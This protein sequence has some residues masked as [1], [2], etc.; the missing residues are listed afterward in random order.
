ME[1]SPPSLFPP[2]AVRFVRMHVDLSWTTRACAG[3]KRQK[4][5]AIRFEQ[6]TLARGL[7]SSY[8]SLWQVNFGSFS[9]PNHPCTDSV[10]S[11][12]ALHVRAILGSRS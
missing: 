3:A 9:E 5:A 8:D 7:V 1:R 12:Q 10:D 2:M 4:P 11:G 6:R